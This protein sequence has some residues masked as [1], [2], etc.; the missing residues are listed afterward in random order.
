M[1][2][3]E[4]QRLACHKLGCRHA[5][6]GCTP[7]QRQPARLYLL[8]VRS[9]LSGQVGVGIEMGTERT[10]TPLVVE[11]V[12]LRRIEPVGTRH[13]RP[14]AA[15]QPSVAVLHLVVVCDRTD[16]M[17]AALYDSGLQLP[18]HTVLGGHQLV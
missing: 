16:R 14:L 12:I 11:D 1:T 2:A 18:R 7:V 13:L 9:M 4:C 6:K 17:L 5:E 3:Y 10:V 8:A 15:Q